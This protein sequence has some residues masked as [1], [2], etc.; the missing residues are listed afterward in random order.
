M[1]ATDSQPEKMMNKQDCLNAAANAER[2]ANEAR[3]R[4][5]LY[6]AVFG[7]KDSLT[8]SAESEMNKATEAAR[9]WAKI[10]EWHPA[11]RNKALRNQTIQVHLFGYSH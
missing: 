6:V 8:I 11:S 1:S 3:G 7:Y 10:A 9:E 4:F 5:A 2:A